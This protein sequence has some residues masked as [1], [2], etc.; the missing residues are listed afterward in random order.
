ME[1][2]IE[3]INLSF[4][5]DNHD[6]EGLKSVRMQSLKGTVVVAGANGS[7]KS[8]LS[9]FVERLTTRPPNFR[10]K[11]KEGLIINGPENI[12]AIR[13]PNLGDVQ[14]HQA[15]NATDADKVTARQSFLKGSTNFGTSLANAIRVAQTLANDYIDTGNALLN[16]DEADK[17]DRVQR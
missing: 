3:S 13:V 17:N 6:V 11:Y 16:L 9:K 7:G 10:V 15:N 5:S 8:R 1:A 12:A 4:D 14:V 2:V